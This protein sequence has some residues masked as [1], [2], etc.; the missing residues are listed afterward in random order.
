MK[1]FIC[2][3]LI[4]FL[5]ACNTYATMYDMSGSATNTPTSTT[6][7]QTVDRAAAPLSPTPAPLMC[8]V[9]TGIDV[10]SLNL[11]SGAGTQYS[12][13]RVLAEKELLTVI[14]RGAWLE[15]QDPQGNHGF[16]NSKYCNLGD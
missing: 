2:A 9:R 13:V 14:A 16:V 11:R 10:G 1:K 4:V 3:L 5:S 7:V 12:V 15:V 8:Q 6:T